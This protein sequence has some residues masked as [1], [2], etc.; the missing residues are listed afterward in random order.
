MEDILKTTAFIY[1]IGLTISL[2]AEPFITPTFFM[3]DE[4]E[5]NTYVL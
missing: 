5:R 3:P 2:A 1:T 4:R